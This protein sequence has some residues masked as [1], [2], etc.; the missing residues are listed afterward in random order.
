[1]TVHSRILLER[2]YESVKALY[3]VYV[4]PK[5]LCRLPIYN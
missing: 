5:V 3:F 4:M 2:G 1:M